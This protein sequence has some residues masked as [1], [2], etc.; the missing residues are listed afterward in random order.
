MFS[1]LFYLQYHSVKNRTVSRLKR[2]K[3]PKYLAG[4]IVGGLYFSYY[5]VRPFMMP[6]QGVQALP[7][8]RLPGDPEWVELIA[9]TALA[10]ITLAAWVLPNRRTVLAFTEAEV[11]FLFPAPISR[12]GLIHYK[13]VRSQ[14]A[15]LFTV[16]LLTLITHRWGGRAWIQ[17]AGWWLMLSTLNLH[18]LGASFARTMLLDRG[19]SNWQRRVGV[20]G[21]VG[22]VLVAAVWWVRQALP[23]LTAPDFADLE[24][25]K[26]YVSS[27][28]NSTPAIVLLFPFRL[29]VGPY[30]AGDALGFL[31]ALPGA[32]GVLLA[33]YAW[34]VKSN[35]AFEEASAEAS[36]KLAEKVAAIRSGNWQ[37]AG[38]K[39]KAGRSPF[40]LSPAGP[41]PTAFFWK[42]LIS[43]NRGITFRTWVII[44]AVVLGVAVGMGNIGG[45][46]TLPVVAGA[47]AAMLAVWSVLLGTQIVRQDFRQD[48]DYL[49][50]LKLFPVAPWQ[51]AFG[52]LL[53]P[54]VILTGVQWLLLAVAAVLVPQTPNFPWRWPAVLSAAL[55]LAMVL[56]ALNFIS[57]V[58]PNAAVLLFPAW[59]QA[60]KEGPQG[61]E[62]TGQ[63]L[64]A[65]LGQFLA[66][67][68]A[69]IPAAL[70]FGAV[71]FLARLAAVW[72]VATP[73]AAL[74]ATA[75][76]A[77]EAAFGIYWLGWLFQ[78]FD[79]S[80]ELNP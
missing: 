71:F 62:T 23:P 5:F 38:G 72:W 14:A 36:R 74:A 27:V 57:L 22:L 51:V 35:V 34:V 63:R 59:L 6:G 12:R 26:S 73:L 50:V 53:A 30:L 39:A 37:A 52:Q 65:F 76:L 1:A 70:A 61:I 10:V 56:P 7:V 46:R 44:A 8:A 32:M 4:A 64:I 45:G 79:I 31:R 24:R 29:V 80:S 67:L 42:N 13:L 49:D 66:F 48:L 33:H 78:R 3:Q 16:L 25:V 15:I 60:G 9:A 2:L 21:A 41:A 20:L 18:L 68:V 54:A 69:L 28:A 58:I 55:S 43:A 75:V 47:I 40:H 17:M 11:A 77:I 19:I